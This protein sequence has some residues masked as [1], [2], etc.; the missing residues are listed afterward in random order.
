MTGA[1]A[2]RADAA[3]H[4]RPENPPSLLLMGL[5]SLITEGIF[6]ASPSIRPFLTLFVLFAS[7]P[8]KS[9]PYPN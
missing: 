9:H 7:C 3:T 8:E 2:T 4:W 6:L 1:L 5:L